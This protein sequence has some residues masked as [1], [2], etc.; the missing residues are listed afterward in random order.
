MTALAIRESGQLARVIRSQVARLVNE[1]KLKGIV[2]VALCGNR[3]SPVPV[4]AF[5]LVRDRLRRKAM[6]EEVRDFL[7]KERLEQLVGEE[8]RRLARNE[9]HPE[10]LSFPDFDRLPMIRI[11]GQGV[12]HA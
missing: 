5:K 6:W 4:S 2:N 12:Y 3:Y 11:E 10:Q 1:A 9:P 8:L 7:A